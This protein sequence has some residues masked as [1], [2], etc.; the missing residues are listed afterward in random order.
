[1]KCNKVLESLVAFLDGELDND[2]NAQIS[3]HLESCSACNKE[4]RLLSETWSILDKFPEL[5]PNE[6]VIRQIQEK[7]KAINNNPESF[8]DWRWSW[9]RIAVLSTAA[10][11]IMTLGLHFMV[12]GLKPPS[13]L[14]VARSTEWSFGQVRSGGQVGTTNQDIKLVTNS[15][16]VEDVEIKLNYYKTLLARFQEIKEEDYLCG[17]DLKVVSPYLFYEEWDF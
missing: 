9:V 14:K 17:D 10:V 13:D 16:N 7:V 8:R 1:M 3:Q 5:E 2:L 4:S 11:L 15:K 12:T 6:K